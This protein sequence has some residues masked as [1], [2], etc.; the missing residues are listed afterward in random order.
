MELND[1]WIWGSLS[2]DEIKES[3]AAVDHVVWPASIPGD[4]CAY[5]PSGS[6]LQTSKNMD[7]KAEN[8]LIEQSEKFGDTF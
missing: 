8:P 6:T 1:Q 7:S 5:A 2:D 4:I 3:E